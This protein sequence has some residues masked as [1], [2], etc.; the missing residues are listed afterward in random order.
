M[1]EASIPHLLDDALIPRRAAKWLGK[2][3]N[4]SAIRPPR[5]GRGEALN[6]EAPRASK[7]VRTT[8]HRVGVRRHSAAFNGPRAARD[9]LLVPSSIVRVRTW[10]SPYHKM[11]MV[12]CKPCVEMLGPLPTVS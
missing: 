4:R 11:S 7:K 12:T 9:A 8:G 2:A 3:E 6:G 10:T 1:L 5:G